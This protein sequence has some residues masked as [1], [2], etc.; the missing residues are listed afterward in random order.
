MSINQCL[1]AH[2][3]THPFP[4]CLWPCLYYGGGVVWQILY[5]PQSHKNFPPDPLLTKLA[6]PHSKQFSE[7]W[8]LSP[9][10]CGM[11]SI[12]SPPSCLQSRSMR[13]ERESHTPGNTAC[14]S[15]RDQTLL[16][17]EK[18]TRTSVGS[19]YT[20]LG[21]LAS[22]VLK[23][24]VLWWSETLWWSLWPFN[25][26]RGGMRGVA[27]SRLNEYGH[28]SSAPQAWLQAAA[29]LWDPGRLTHFSLPDFP[30]SPM[31]RIL[32]SRLSPMGSLWRLEQK[33]LSS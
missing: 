17:S 21:S 26:R 29:C 14:K 1:W 15:S 13:G 20:L 11:K 6:D 32:E 18:V 16:W 12:W 33:L 10:Y 7:W 24:G 4:C 23:Q 30:C 22:M 2:K 3:H 5:D 27:E 9:P 31:R 28:W 25:W 8:I 19:L